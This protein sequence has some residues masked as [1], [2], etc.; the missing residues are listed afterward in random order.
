MPARTRWSTEVGYSGLSPSGA[1][2]MHRVAEWFQDAAVHA[3]REGGYPPSRYET[4][5]R[6]WFVKELELI[7]DHPIEY[8]ETITVETWISDVRRFRSHREYRVF[9]GG[10]RVVAR[11]RVDWLFLEQDPATRKVRPAIPDEEMVTAFPVVDERA[12]ED[13]LQLIIPDAPPTLEMHRVV[14]PSEIDRHDHVN[15]TAYVR[16]IEDLALPIQR[17]QLRF[18]KDARPGDELSVRAWFD[19]DRGFVEARRADGRILLAALK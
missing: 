6:S 1:T 8:G 5:G 13:P 3:S 12:I 15:H 14:R 18:E 10:G 17:I 11:G 7:V 4:M 19:G 2:R 16:W 9:D